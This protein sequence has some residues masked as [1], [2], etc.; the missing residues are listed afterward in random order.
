MKIMPMFIYVIYIFS[1]LLKSHLCE[2]SVLLTIYWVGTE[3]CET[4]LHSANKLHVLRINLPWFIL[5]F[6]WV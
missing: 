6:L 3:C 4:A 2:H 5:I 1:S